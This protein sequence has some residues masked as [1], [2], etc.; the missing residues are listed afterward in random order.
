MVFSCH[1]QLKIAA[2]QKSEDPERTKQQHSEATCQ[3]H[4]QNNKFY[5]FVYM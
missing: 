1:L 3:E 5:V 2:T 4:S